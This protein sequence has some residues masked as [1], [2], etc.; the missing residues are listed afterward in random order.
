[1]EVNSRPDALCIVLVVFLSFFFGAHKHFTALSCF[2]YLMRIHAVSLC[3]SARVKWIQFL[4]V[5]ACSVHDKESFFKMHLV[6]VDLCCAVVCLAHAFCAIF[7]CVVL[8]FYDEWRSHKLTQFHNCLSLRISRLQAIQY[9]LR[10][11]G[12][13]FQLC[14]KF[15][16]SFKLHANDAAPTT[17][18]RN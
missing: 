13:C 18:V 1:M 2:I 7:R 6:C 9:R 3:S 10:L 15:N 14:F 4:T 11:C 16:Y 12:R 8:M 5:C 17:S